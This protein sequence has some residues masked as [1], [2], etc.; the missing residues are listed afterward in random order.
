MPRRSVKTHKFVDLDYTTGIHKK[1]SYGFFIFLI[2]A[3]N[4][5]EYYFFKGDQDGRKRVEVVNIN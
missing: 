2:F 5:F 3:P 4:S 1:L